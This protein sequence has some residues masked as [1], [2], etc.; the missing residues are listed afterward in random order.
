[1]AFLNALLQVLFN[2]LHWPVALAAGSIV[3]VLE[4]EGRCECVEGGREGEGGA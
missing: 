4:V 2:A 1:M 3:M